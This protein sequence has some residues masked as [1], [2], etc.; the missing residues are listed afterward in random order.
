M[1]STEGV[2]TLETLDTL[3]SLL[4]H[5]TREG[6]VI[7]EGE[8]GAGKTTFIKHLLSKLGVTDSVTSPTFSL[9]QHYK[10]AKKNIIHADLYRIKHPAEIEGLGIEYDGKNLIL[11]EWGERFEHLFHPLKA[12]IKFNYL[13]SDN[14]N[15]RAF[16]LE[17]F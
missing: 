10:A 2:V 6:F 13:A 11:I 8:L 3:S 15:S 1:V 4:L 12:K 17:L 9:V 7:L 14:I 16:S 5:H